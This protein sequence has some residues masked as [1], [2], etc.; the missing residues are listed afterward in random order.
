METSGEMQTSPKE[1]LKE[2]CK[3]DRLGFYFLGFSLLLYLL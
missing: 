3:G 2:V 1:N